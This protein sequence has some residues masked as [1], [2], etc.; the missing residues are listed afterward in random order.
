[1]E[2]GA[3]VRKDWS[4]NRAIRCWP[5]EQVHYTDPDTLQNYRDAGNYVYAFAL[6]GAL[7]DAAKTAKW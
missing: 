7:R 4:R 5:G 3:P 6:E 2:R 1:M